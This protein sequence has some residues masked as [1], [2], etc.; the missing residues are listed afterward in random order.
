MLAAHKRETYPE[1]P[2]KFCKGTGL[3]DR[4]TNSDAERNIEWLLAD[5]LHALARIDA[6]AYELA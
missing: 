6:S 4:A 3:I 1:T 5:E 2:P